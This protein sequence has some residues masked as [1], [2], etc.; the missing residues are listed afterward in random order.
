MRSTSHRPSATTT[1]T[2]TGPASA[3]PT[4]D[5]ENPVR[6]QFDTG[7]HVNVGEEVDGADVQFCGVWFTPGEFAALIDYIGAP[8]A[9][10]FTPEEAE[11]MRG[12]IR[13]NCEDTLRW[14][15]GTH[16]KYA[17]LAQA[18]ED[19]FAPGGTGTGPNHCDAFVDQYAQAFAMAQQAADHDEPALMN[20]ARKYGYGAEHF[21]EDMFS[22]GH[23]VSAEVIDGAVD[24]IWSTPRMAVA[25]AGIAGRVWDRCADT[26]RRY[27]SRVGGIAV[28]MVESEFVAIGVAGGLAKGESGAQ[29]AVRKFVHEQLEVGVEV[30]SPAHP[31]PWVLTGDHDLATNPT[32]ISALELALQDCRQLLE[33]GAVPGMDPRKVAVDLLDRHRPI[34]TG[35]GQRVIAAAVAEATEDLSA[36]T[37]AMVE[38]MSVT[39][40]D[41]MDAVCQETGGRI[42]RLVDPDPADPSPELP[43]VLPEIPERRLPVSYVPSRRGAALGPTLPQTEAR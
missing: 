39:I 1:T 35:A 13:A 30:S 3:N 10:G 15:E 4:L 22:A 12:L 16:G 26:I 43:D 14:N 36:L 34:P 11:A 21:L 28:P 37:D 29:D 18:N 19:H 9:T 42:V 6:A 31:T 27:G 25:Y 5:A 7:T 24:A 41:V 23:Q 20:E 2:D 40:G 17:A 38:A 33:L 8:S 32:S